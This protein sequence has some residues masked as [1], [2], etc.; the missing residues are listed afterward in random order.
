MTAVAVDHLLFGG[1]LPDVNSVAL[2]T[3]AMQGAD[4][5][6]SA[7][8]VAPGNRSISRVLIPVS[9][10]VGN[11]VAQ[12]IEY[13]L[14]IEGLAVNREP[15]GMAHTTETIPTGALSAGNT[16]DLHLLTP[17]TPAAGELVTINIRVALVTPS[18]S[19]H[20][21]FLEGAQPGNFQSHP[22]TITSTDGSTFTTSV[23]S[24]G[25]TPVDSGGRGWQGF[26]PINNIANTAF[27][28]GTNPNR[29]GAL[30]VAP[31]DGV[32]G[33]VR[34]NAWPTAGSAEFNVEVY[35]NATLERALAFPANPAFA[36]T[37]GVNALRVFTVNTQNLAFE[38]GDELRA[39]IRPTNTVT[40]NRM[41][42]FDTGSEVARRV[43]SGDCI[44][45]EWD[46]SLSQWVNNS[47]RAYPVQFF[48]REV[49]IGNGAPGAGRGRIIGG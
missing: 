38:E 25:L 11:P 32:L 37:P 6:L 40:S 17:Y 23:R 36:G 45:T 4:H 26:A 35:R 21:V 27:D 42:R 20:V 48:L 15:D 19:H 14:T 46:T 12:G 8:F 3:F 16:L 30:L 2:T 10:V 44:A 41:I 34:M 22:Y 49:E 43:L 31:F 47:N 24:P 9:S 39:V 1:H 28:S 29:R 33:H 13:E 7:A 5:V 18:A